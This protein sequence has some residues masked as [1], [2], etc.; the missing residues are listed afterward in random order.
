MA[1]AVRNAPDGKVPL[2]IVHVSGCR[3]TGDLVMLRL[4]DFEDWFGKIGGKDG[5]ADV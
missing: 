4:G 3:H 1:Q 2:V 5:S